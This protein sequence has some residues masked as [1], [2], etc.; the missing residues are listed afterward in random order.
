MIVNH[1]AIRQSNN[2]L[3]MIKNYL[4]TAWRNLWKNKVYSTINIAG[5]AIGMAACI[6][7]LL[8]VFYER[9]FDRFHSK[10]IYRLNEVQKFEGMVASQKVALSMYPM[11]PTLKQEFPEIINFSRIWA[12]NKTPLVLGEK[13]VY[14]DRVAFVDSTF[15]QMF[16]FT[17]LKGQRRIALNEKNSIVLTQTTARKFFGEEDPLGKTL[18]HYDDDTTTMVVTGILADVPENSQL[19]FDALVPFSTIAE[20]DWMTQWGGNWLNTYLELAPGTAV[21]ALEK[22]FPAYLKKYLTDRDRW[23]N[24][25]LFLLPLIDVHA[26]A[27]DIGLDSFNYKQFD[28]NYT[29][30]FFI[31]ACKCCLLPASIL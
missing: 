13:R 9:S 27:S 1:Q 5:L 21:S 20:P 26:G 6:I 23:K 22:K 24:Y 11:G 7:I 28:K 17:L 4:K 19:Q 30:L 3:I 2:L 25:E 16:D 29:N 12:S 8:F 14:I 31:I 10:N 15:L 18:M